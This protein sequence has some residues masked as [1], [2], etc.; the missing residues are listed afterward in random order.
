[1]KNVFYLVFLS[2]AMMFISTSSYAQGKGNLRGIVTDKAG[3]I[4]PGASVAVKG[5]T[6]G[7]AT[8]MNGSY[9][10]QGVSTGD[11]DIEVNYLGYEPIVKKITVEAGK[12]VIADFILNEASF[13][14]TGVVVSAVV[15]GQQRALNQQK[16]A[17]NMMQVVSADQMGKF[18]DPNVADALKRLSG[19]TTDGKEVQLRGTPA[20]FTNINVNGE[21]IMGSQ[22]SG[23]RNEALDV[24]PSDLLASMEVQKTLLPSNDGDAISGVINMRTGTARSLNPKFSIDLGS[25]YSWLREKAN[26]NAKISYAQRFFPT[27]K[28]QN[29]VLGITANYSFLR[30]NKGYDRIEA[31]AWEPY[32]LTNKTT[33]E[34]V[35]E[36][37]YIP[38]DFRYRYQSTKSTRNGLA[39]V[40]DVAPTVNTKFTFSTILNK[41]KDDEVRYRNRYRFRDNGSG[42]YVMDDGSIGSER[43]RNI[44][45]VSTQNEKINNI[46][47]NLDG[48]STIGTW[49]IDGGLFYTKSKRDYQSEMMGFQTPEWRAGKKVNGATIAK[50]T[51]IGTMPSIDTKYL[52]YDY[53]FEPSG[54]MGTEATDA[55]SR[56]NLYTVE[57]NN[58]VTEGNSFTVRANASKNYF[59]KDYA[60]TLSFGFKGKFMDNSGHI[61]DG[62]NTYAITAS[63]ANNLTNLLYKEKLTS[64]FLN[65]NL[66]FNTAPS[67]GKIKSYLNDPANAGDISVNEYFSGVNQDGFYYDVSENVY[68]GYVMNKVQFDKVMLLAGARIEHTRVDYKANKLTPFVNPSAPIQNGDATLFNDYTSEPVSEKL[69]YTKFLPNIQV[70]ADMSDKTILRL[71]WTTGYSRP[72]VTDLVPKQDVSQDLQRVTLGNPDLKPAYS[73]NFD[74]LLEQYMSNVG[75]LSL[76]VFHKSIADFQYLSEGT[77]NNSA[78]AFDGWQ[79]I[80]N[81]NGDAAKVFGAEFTI[82]SNLTF[83]P[84]FLKNLVFT[85][86]YTYVFSQATTDEDRG[87]TRL[88]GQAES[89]ANFALAYSTDRFTLQA[90]TNY[91]GSYIT[92]LGANSERDIWQDGRWQI[93]LNGSVKIYKGLTLWM[94]V[95]NLLNSEYYTYF[96]NK[97]RVYNLQYNGATARGGFSYKF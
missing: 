55:T 84:S 83:L 26:Y 10:L 61:P 97:S 57:N 92:A 25:G 11:I 39:F 71:S 82:N 56:Y 93:D 40:V 4:L 30:S 38:T 35:S 64:S 44:T 15:G 5:T 66:I 50:G 7:V 47:L 23:K 81:R 14:I 60:S 75:I 43:M 46:N 74:L 37:T 96:G 18:P 94:E 24:I 76:G 21:Q 67:Y 33:G 48:E 17:D 19:V 95:V 78:S 29:G 42:F 16:V 85:S 2:I 91:I 88:P 51:V 59:V 69:N 62:T 22:E 80:Q 86:N 54:A 77:Y 79:L 72:N 31:E 73:N 6:L 41:R 8:D 63:D 45:Q 13:T 28:N 32:Q 58:T 87:S 49:K 68:A 53:I 90:S 36:E 89:T 12:T 1:M 3:D 52:T 27:N 65:N 20:S 34:V 70:K 9:V